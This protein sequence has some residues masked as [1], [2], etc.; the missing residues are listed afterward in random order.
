MHNVWRRDIMLGGL[1]FL[2]MMLVFSGAIQADQRTFTLDIRER[3]V[4]VT[5]R[6]IRVTQGDAVTIRWTTDEAVALHLHGYDIETV[7]KPGA[8]AEMTSKAHAT[9][10]FPI[11]SHGFGAHAHSGGHGES[12]LMYIEVLPR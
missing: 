1:G 3:Q 5:S 10:R 8:V 12:T 2:S 6:T 9:G 7:I 11:T 4:G